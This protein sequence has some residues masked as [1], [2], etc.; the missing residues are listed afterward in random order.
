MDQ[1]GAQRFEQAG[2]GPPW[3]VI[4]RGTSDARSGVVGRP[5]TAPIVARSPEGVVLGC[6]D[7][8]ECGP[9]AQEASQACLRRR[10]AEAVREQERC[11]RI[12]ITAGHDL[13]Q[14]L[15]VLTMLL[16]RIAFAGPP[17]EGRVRGRDR[18][19]RPTG[20]R[21]VRARRRRPGRP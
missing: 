10:L 18:D 16:D 4:F 6:L 12:M 21:V 15:Q 5:I 1:Q 19:G 11:Q 17:E 9:R 3:S 20:P 8:P 7:A 13:R 2:G 14:P